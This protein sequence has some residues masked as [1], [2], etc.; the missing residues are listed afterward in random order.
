MKK[1]LILTLIMFF[2]FTSVIF[3]SVVTF[4]WD[5]NTETDL[6]GYKLYQAETEGGP[7]IKAQVVGEGNLVAIIQTSILIDPDNPEYTLQ[8]VA[9]GTHYW[10]M[11]ARDISNNESDFSNE[12]TT[13]IDSIPPGP[14]GGLTIW[15]VI[16]AAL[17][18]VWSWFADL[19]SQ[20]DTLRTVG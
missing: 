19:F 3:A 10:V 20:S 1:I 8:D 4:R 14:P 16:V 18:N 5:A 15:E 2:M 7:Y 11:T 13:T 12:V 17:K 6:W 9:D